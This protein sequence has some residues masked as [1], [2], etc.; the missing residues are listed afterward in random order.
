MTQFWT[1]FSEVFDSVKDSF[2][3]G[4][5]S[6]HLSFAYLLVMKAP[7]SFIF[8]AV[9]SIYG[10]SYL[11]GLI[12]TFTGISASF[13]PHFGHFPSY[14]LIISSGGFRSTPSYNKWPH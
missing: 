14:L 5:F 10:G 11:H 6:L 9:N 8:L 4:F 2:F 7:Y 12:S 13:R 3:F 1:Y